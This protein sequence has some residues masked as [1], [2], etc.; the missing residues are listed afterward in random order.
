M[1]IINNNSFSF[2]I[3]STDL[4]S[5][6]TS[7]VHGQSHGEFSTKIRQ[8]FRHLPKH[9]KFRLSKEVPNPQEILHQSN[10][11]TDTFSSLTSSDPQHEICLVSDSPH[12]IVRVRL[13][14]LYFIHYQDVYL[15]LLELETLKNLKH[16]FLMIY[17]N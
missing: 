11:T 1:Q 16:S 17:Q 8:I 5:S 6:D 2:V 14:Y 12:Y 15:R 4:S 3:I 10:V 7:N 13:I 9:N